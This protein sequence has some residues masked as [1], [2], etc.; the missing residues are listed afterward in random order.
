MI[1]FG[2]TL[3]SA[4]EAKGLSVA[5]VAE[6]THM[7]PSTIEDME[8][9]DFSRIAAPIYGRGFV[10]LYCEAVGLAPK[11]FIDEFMEIYNGN[12][13]TVIR[14]RIVAPIVEEPIEQDVPPPPEPDTAPQPQQSSDEAADESV[15]QDLFSQEPQVAPAQ[16]FDG[17]SARLSRYAAPVSQTR[18][19]H[20]SMNGIMPSTIFRIGAI[21]CVAVVILWVVFIGLR[22]LHRATSATPPAA[23]DAAAESPRQEERAEAQQPA[24]PAADAKPQAAKT[25]APRQLQDIPA[26]YID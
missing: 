13:D 9:E 14:E 5:A 17:A 4:R 18:D 3:R 24:P 1:E 26:L 25:A 10:K 21:A 2:K 20:E 8:K 23:D 22:A 15:E 16:D 7:A 19:S 11:P 6:L 12:R